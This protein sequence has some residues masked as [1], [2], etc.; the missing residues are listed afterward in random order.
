MKRILMSFAL[1]FAFALNMAA[2]DYAEAR[3]R[4]WF[5][6]DKMAYEL[7]LTPEQ[8]DIA[9]Q[10]NL[11]YLLSIR[12]PSDCRG[13]YWHY[14]NTDLR[15][16]LFDW[17]Y[18]LFRSLEYFYRPVRW[19]HASWYYPVC[20]HYR[21]GY[22]YFHRP[23]IYVSYRGCGW[24]RRGRSDRSPYYG[25]RI[26]RR[27]GLR[28][29]YDIRNHRGNQRLELKPS[30]NGGR[31]GNSNGFRDND[32]I[33]IENRFDS[34]REG[35]ITITDRHNSSRK[36]SPRRFE[37]NKPRIELKDKSRYSNYRGPSRQRSH[38][39][40]P[41]NLKRKES[42]RTPRA[43]R[44]EQNGRIHRISKRNFD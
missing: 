25:M 22:Y 32:R 37:N 24:H 23:T 4:A 16:I 9:Y 44:H 7:D 31:I 3:E 11:D 42:I 19:V 41:I 5:L 17:Q 35:R 30:R 36:V 29:Q 26:T 14:R 2:M 40:R 43:P 1:M 39:D 15:Y 8:Y 21:Y 6:T 38:T 27:D 18:D 13:R 33:N 34:K 12:T 20:R 10:I 28:H